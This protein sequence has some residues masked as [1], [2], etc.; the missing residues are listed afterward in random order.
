MIDLY[1]DDYYDEDEDY[2]NL[3]TKKCSNKKPTP[4]VNKNNAKP[5]VLNTKPVVNT[6]G[7]QKPATKTTTQST[8]STKIAETKQQKAVQSDKNNL[9]S[10][11]P[12]Q[13]TVITQ[14][15][16]KKHNHTVK[17][18]SELNATKYPK[19]DYKL[20]DTTDDKQNINLVIIG[21]VDSGKSTLMG[22][23]LYLV[24]QISDKTL[25]KYEK[26]SKKLGKNTFHFAWAMDE[27]TEERKRGVTVDIAYKYFETK[28]KKVTVM[29][30]PGHRDFVPNMIT[31]TSAADAAVLVV[32]SNRNSFEAGFFQ[33]GQTKEH[34]VLAR[35][36]G[37]KQIIVCIN[38]L[39]LMEWSK[40]RY[41]YIQAQIRDFLNNL[42]FK[43]KDI[44]FV[45]V[46]GLNGTNIVKNDNESIKELAWYEGKGL[47]E[48][49]DSLEEPARDNESP[50]RFSISDC[51]FTAINSLQGVGIFG[52][53]ESGIIFEDE[54]YLILPSNLKTKIRSIAVDNVKVN[55]IKAGQ[56][57]ELLLTLDKTLIDDVRSGNVLCSIEYPVP[58]VNS[59]KVQIITLDIKAPLSIGQILFIHCQSQKS[60]AK[61]KKIHKIFSKD[62]KTSKLNPV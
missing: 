22:H 34:A 52:K 30:A 11:T 58:V 60:S 20:Q 45:P 62:G 51:S 37:V 4:V 15:P 31:G 42:D 39:E 18:P 48:F 27:D 16:V 28:N 59:I 7:A 3:S 19:I 32:D 35:S 61:I 6:T 29:D 5:Q 54:E 36:L 49:V 46:S 47:L 17:I 50:A 9:I 53:L 14:H 26:E 13:Q 23:L 12:N 10:L 56:N 55:Y 43:D 2:D 24:G 41:D 57:A 38:K 21:H 40:E 33:G 25:Q 44:F 8:Q 1:D